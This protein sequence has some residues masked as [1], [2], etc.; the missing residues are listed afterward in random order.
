MSTDD[1]PP[2]VRKDDGTDVTGR[3]AA[4]AA[5]S[6][7]VGSPGI[8]AGG[9]ESA[10][11]KR[12]QR[13]KLIIGGAMTAGVLTLANRPAIASG[14]S[15]SLLMSHTNNPNSSSDPPSVWGQPPSYWTDAGSYAWTAGAT[16]MG[17]PVTYTQT[18]TLSG[19]FP[20]LNST[21]GNVKFTIQG[22]ATLGS[23]INAGSG[24]SVL[25]E[26]ANKTSVT[27]LTSA[28]L[29]QLVAGLLNWYFFGSRY[30]VANVPNTIS[31]FFTNV[32]NDAKANN[33]SGITSAASSL[34]G[35]SGTI[36]L[37]NN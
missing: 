31:T 11:K 10:D 29:A 3:P 25:V 8:S 36:Y 16:F 14:G 34:F 35:T 32:F 4:V 7:P 18:T 30:P 24:D 15:P 28:Q 6:A 17:A 33:A 12:A 37:A 5:P 2:T 22:S 23:E 1:V 21:S 19:A 27:V 20:T 26:M 9:I 13:R